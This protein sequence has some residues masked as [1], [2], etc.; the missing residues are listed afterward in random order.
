[1]FVF[2]EALLEIKKLAVQI[3]QEFAQMA[4]FA[5]KKLIVSNPQA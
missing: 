2:L 5:M 4:Q 3:V 1:M